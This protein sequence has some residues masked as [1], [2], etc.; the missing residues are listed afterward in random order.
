M[1]QGR[2][3]RATPG[4]R[5]RP[6]LPPAARDRD[7]G[8]VDSWVDLYW[9]PLGAG[10]NTHCVR[11]NGRVFETLTAGLQRRERCDLYHAALMVRLDADEY[12]IE[13][14]P[15]WSSEAADRG[16]MLEGPVGL[17]VL[18]HSRFFRYEV[19]CWRG[20]VIPDLAEAVESPVR[21]SDTRSRA[22]RL[23]ALVPECPPV[24][25]G[26]DDLRAGEMW[27]SNSL[28]AWLL[29]RSGH[30][31]DALHPPDGGRAPGWQAGLAVARRAGDAA[32][33]QR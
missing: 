3:S 19:R 11:T 16:V 31:V 10:D 29:A 24:T 4:D 6:A 33:L 25:W 5:G 17:R 32:P 21:V 14:A 15:V 26:R 30:D 7:R 8:V 18:G 12:V 20:G 1:A 27:N 2:W 22:A 13:M 23:L 28:V 9:L